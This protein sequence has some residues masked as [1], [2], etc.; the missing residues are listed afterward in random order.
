MNLIEAQT[1]WK[2][3]NYSA[4]EIACNSINDTI[5]HSVHEF[6]QLTIEVRNV[7]PDFI[8]EVEN[9]IEDVLNA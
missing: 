9:G 3:L 2:I 5:G 1:S 6:E 8:I 4:R 7:V